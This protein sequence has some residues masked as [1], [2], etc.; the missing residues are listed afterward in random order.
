LAHIAFASYE[1][2]P[3]TAGGA[4]VFVRSAVEA[5]LRD[6]HR[7]SVLLDIPD[8]EFER[9]QKEDSSDLPNRS[10]LRSVRVDAACT[11]MDTDRGAFPSEAHWRSRRFAHALAKLHAAVPVD[12]AEF[13]DYCGSA[14][15][16]AVQR[17]A[18]PAMFP[19]L[20]GVRLHNTIEVMDRRVASE[21][22]PSRLY[23]YGLERAALSLADVVLSSGQAYWDEE[24]ASL[25]PGVTDA[26]V[27]LSF[28][29]RRPFP[30]V[31]GAGAGKDIVYVGRA[32]TF[33]GMD[34]VLH[35]ATALLGD[36]GLRG[37]LRRF[38]VIGPSETV[39]SSRGERELLSIG[40]GLA[41]DRLVLAGHQPEREIRR[42]FA[43]AAVAIFPNRME[44]FC[45]AAHE[46][47][48]A[49]VP[50][51]VSDT[52]TFRDHFVDG[53]TALF[54]NNTVGDLVAKLRHCLLDAEL[55]DRLSRSVERYRDRYGRH[56]YG[57]HLA[58][59]PFAPT[60]TDIVSPG[61]VLVPTAEHPSVAQTDVAALAD[62]LPG[63]MIWRLEPAGP[64][65][66]DVLA[67]GRRWRILDSAGKVVPPST[68]VLPAAIAFLAATTRKAAPF[69]ATAA[70]M[71][72]NEPR[73]AAVFP[74][75]T[76]PDGRRTTSEAPVLLERS[77]SIGHVI[78]GAVQRT[79]PGATLAD[80]FEDGT[81]LTEIASLLRQ[82]AAGGVLVD[83]PSLGF[84]S[85][86]TSLPV[87]TTGAT[88]RRLLRRFAWSVDRVL[89]A[90][91]LAEL[92]EL[93][94]R[95]HLTD[96]AA[97][98]VGPPRT[99]ELIVSVSAQPGPRGAS[100]RATLLAVRRNPGS[101]SVP[102]AALECSGIWREVKTQD[103]PN[104]M[105][106]GEG[107]RLVL[108]LA[109]DPEVTVLL[110]PDQD[111]V[112]FSLDGQA[113]RLD[114]QHAEYR[115]LT[116]R[117]RDLLVLAAVPG[118][119][120]PGF[121]TRSLLETRLAGNV[122]DMI[123]SG[124]LCA[125]LIETSG[126]GT[127]AQAMGFQ[128]SNQRLRVLPV[129]FRDDPSAVGRAIAARTCAV[130]LFG[131]PALVPVIDALL[132]GSA[133]VE[134]TYTLRPTFC[135]DAGGWEWLSSV[136][137]LAQRFGRRLRLRATQGAVTAGL[138]ALNALVETADIVLP[139]ASVTPPPGPVSLLLPAART[140]VPSCGHIAAAA[141]QLYGSGEVGTIHL[142]K[143]ET[144]TL[145][146]LEQF[147]VAHAVR[148]HNEA[149]ELVTSLAGSRLLYC[150]PF[151]DSCFDPLVLQV[152]SIGGLALSAPGPLR[153]ADLVLRET[154]EVVAWED[155][156]QIVEHLRRAI[157]HYDQLIARLAETG[158]A[159]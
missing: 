2:S 106:V 82:R 51:I 78:L 147:G 144:H 91:E 129:G 11:D 60:T 6:G 42:F 13:F 62:E 111:A 114:L 17:A 32:S 115:Q 151:A 118:M 133:H 39:S 103:R 124:A 87:S 119:V 1:I 19:P 3:T 72:G 90:D 61:V 73:I 10:C 102:V 150:T 157:V 130:S 14:Y 74:A 30:R 97:H 109:D 136:A 132:N 4:G 25:Y 34:R 12:F 76:S 126:D 101:P 148:Q 56:D 58:T 123:P 22:A 37:V 8:A 16:A 152:F 43:D 33:K 105:I 108:P 156:R 159:A 98:E 100:S 64:E 53:D 80:L 28:P 107:G 40:R 26:R 83:H 125:E 134:V 46:A 89:V 86:G 45:Y 135:W 154:L 68:Q 84:S 110:G 65:E 122:L 44:S 70:R 18:E 120:E 5:L 117:I 47:H 71:L 116:I 94:D 121:R 57:R 23:D 31:E 112:S 140:S 41:P 155:P 52:P 38:V 158:A 81:A 131:G 55:R 66:P 104:P 48:L 142:P 20:I 145:K 67:F 27:Q 127:L 69:L 29:V 141:A 138:R 128:A 75:G 149:A 137:R 92:S 7:V 54:F 50:L 35:A 9:W 143:A 88:R 96:L 24:C 59:A 99:G 139:R 77:G 85:A 79:S 95:I 15:Y 153:H 93:S 146:I 63:A 36:D 21:F 113:A 49:G